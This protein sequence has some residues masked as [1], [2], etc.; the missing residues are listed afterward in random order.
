MQ[1]RRTFACLNWTRPQALLAPASP[2]FLCSSFRC[3]RFMLSVICQISVSQLHPHVIL[4]SNSII[5][6]FIL[7]PSIF[8]SSNLLRLAMSGGYDLHSWF[9]YS[10]LLFFLSTAG[11]WVKLDLLCG[12]FFY[13]SADVIKFQRMITKFWWI[14]TQVFL[15]ADDKV[16]WRT[17]L[18]W[19]YSYCSHVSDSVDTLLH[20]YRIRI[21]SRISGTLLL[22]SQMDFDQ[23]HYHQ[24]TAVRILPKGFLCWEKYI[25]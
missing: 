9:T 6:C 15:C 11:F 21:F 5:V 20:L 3:H 18:I 10:M 16:E 13:H 12:Y 8:G 24:I 22:S 7:M 1:E 14:L 17:V 4:P 2:I 23:H 25:K 19:C